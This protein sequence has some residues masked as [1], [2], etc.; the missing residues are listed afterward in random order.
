MATLT[1]IGLL[2]LVVATI[3]AQ[4]WFLRLG[5]RWTRSPQLSIARAILAYLAIFAVNIVVGLLGRLIPDSNAMKLLVVILV[6]LFVNVV[7]LALMLRTTFWR[8]TGTYL[9]TLIPNVVVY[10]LAVW[11]LRP[12]ITEAFAIPTNSMAPTLLGKHLTGVCP[13]CGGAAYGSPPERDWMSRQGVPMICSR[14]MKQCLVKNPP[15]EIGGGDRLLVNKRLTPKRWDLI[16]F[17]VPDD[18]ATVY[19]RLVGLPGE[20][21]TIREGAVWAN[22]EKL[23]PPSEVGVLHY[24]DAREIAA[25]FGANWGSESNPAKLGA[26]EYFMLGD[27]SSAARDSRFWETG[28]P[29]HP[30]YAVP[31]DHIVGVV[32]HIYWPPSR[33]R[34]FR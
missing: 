1:L 27:N 11:V 14:E 30:P 7:V 6:M 21:I 34:A 18:P 19:V 23:I 26:G 33:C 20:E 24:L 15:S 10:G 12:Y 9:A 22:G 3:A 28:A 2:A 13:R 31:Q 4:I 32:T 29:G 25:G 5:A 16:V 8:A 17:R